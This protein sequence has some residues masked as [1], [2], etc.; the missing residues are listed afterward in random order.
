MPR[1]KKKNLV[2]EEKNI[3]KLGGYI[4]ISHSNK[5]SVVWTSPDFNE[6][7]NIWRN[8]SIIGDKWKIY[9]VSTNLLNDAKKGL[10][11]IKED[12]DYIKDNHMIPEITYLVSYDEKI[13]FEFN[14][15]VIKH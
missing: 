5:N 9:Q 4:C 14:D 13:D 7:I 6:A 10:L 2:T 3:I 1:T 15:A 8:S 12:V 11:S